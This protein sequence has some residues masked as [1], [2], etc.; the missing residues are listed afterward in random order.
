MNYVNATVLFEALVAARGQ[1]TA[2]EEEAVVVRKSHDCLRLR[3]VASGI[4]L[5]ITHGPADSS[6][7]FWLELYADTV[8]PND[9]SLAN[10]IEYGLDLMFPTSEMHDEE[11]GQVVAP[12]RSLAT[13]LNLTTPVR[14]SEDYSMR[15]P[16]PNKVAGDSSKVRS[17]PPEPPGGLREE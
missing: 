2:R 17:L 4:V 16:E 11:A 6:E 8:A 12:N 9:A 5:E 15:H 13:N 7:R 3:P 14:G 1:L 10:C